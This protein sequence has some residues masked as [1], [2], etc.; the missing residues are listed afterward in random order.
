MHTHMGLDARAF[1]QAR[2]YGTVTVRPLT[3]IDRAEWD[4]LWKGYLDFYETTLPKAQYDL[5]FARYLDP[6][7]PM[8]A[9]LAEHEGKPRGLTHII[10]HRHG[11]RDGPTCY[12]QDL[13]ADPE[14]RGTGIGR[15]LIEHVYHVTKAA[16]GGRVYWMTHET[17]AVGRRLYDRIADR[18]GFIQ[19][20]KTL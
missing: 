4:R 2:V 8:F 9:Y 3:K 15:A 6:A 7:E 18:T 13:Y 19:Y 10:L 16:G 11:W 17:N 5:T 14:L 1:D 20:A 12:L